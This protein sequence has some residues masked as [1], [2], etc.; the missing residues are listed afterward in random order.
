MVERTILLVDDDA[1]VLA[2]L[3]RFFE[4]RG[5]QV[6]R[7]AEAEGALAFYEQERPDLVLLDLNLPG[8]SG[9]RV[10]EVLTA[11]DA[12]ATVIMLTGQAD[13]AV[14][15]EAMRLGAENFLTKPVELA[16]LEAAAERAWEK[17][18]L[19]RRERFQAL[20]RSAGA[21]VADLFGGTPSMK[22]LGRQVERLA[23][24]DA[25]VLILGETG[26]GKRWAGRMLHALS[27]RAAEPFV[28]FSCAGVSAGAAEL[29][30]LGRE[31]VAAA[32]TSLRRG[33]FEVARAGTLFLDEVDELA[34]AT[35]PVLL[36]VLESRRLRRV[37]GTREIAVGTRVVAASS[38]DPADLLYR[39]DALP[40]RLP[41][42]R[43]RG[44]I[45]I[46]AMAMR[47][48]LEL[49]RP[50][51]PAPD[52]FSHDALALIT[53][54]DWPG[55]V[56]Q[57]RNV[58]ERVLLLSNGSSEVGPADLPPELAGGTGPLNGMDD[59]ALSLAEVERRHIA[60]VL[61]VHAG[62]R[63]SAARSLGIS[64][65]TLYEKL[66]RYGLDQVGRTHRRR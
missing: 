7:A 14:A 13:V 43:E 31:H 56:R 22:E 39:L 59:A 32:G 29:E 66:A 24:S 30:L 58:V 57:L 16:H 8:P 42:L 37:G 48:L 4:R 11:R 19:R 38:H 33:L 1:E 3:G 17:A 45:E 60:R 12:D 20:E 27:A 25:T 54:Y 2:M 36:R 61:A 53:A 15:V 6:Q 46:A 51:A 64:R 49:R 5:W 23:G 63:S 35:Q 55:N 52:R 21:P 65:A 47:F 44:R 62:N 40:L 50:G 26:T 34:A 10:L 9:L 18:L 41:P 28:E